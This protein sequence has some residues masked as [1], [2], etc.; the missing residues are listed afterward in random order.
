M[1][2]LELN[3][4]SSL[5]VGSVERTD[6]TDHPKQDGW[7]EERLRHRHHQSERGW[8]GKGKTRT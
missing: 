5:L 4:I 6:W 8:D 2:V 7:P 3:Q 1:P